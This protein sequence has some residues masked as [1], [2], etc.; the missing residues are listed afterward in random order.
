MVLEINSIGSQNDQREYSN[1]LKDYFTKYK[2]ELD[3]DSLKR[4]SKNQ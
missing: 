2:K 1:K 4:L 3:E